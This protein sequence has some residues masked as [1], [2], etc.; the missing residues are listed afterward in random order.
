MALSLQRYTWSDFDSGVNQLLKLR[1]KKE[2]ERS[3]LLAIA[4]KNGDRLPENLMIEILSW[5]PVKN[6]LQF[7]SVC[8][9][10]R[11]VISSPQFISKHLKN[12]RKIDDNCLLAQY[13]VSHAELQLFELL[14]DEASRVLASE[15]LYSMPMYGAYICGPCDG[16][17]YLYEYD[18]S[19]R[20]LWNPA[21]NEIRNLPPL[22][23]KPDPPINTTPAKSE[24]YS[25]GVDPV[26]GDYKV[27]VIK[28]Y[29]STN[30]EDVSYPLSV[31][32]YSLRTDSWKYCGDLT[33]EYDLASNK[34]YIFVE[35]SCF[36]LGS[37]SQDGDN[38][39]EVIVSFDM[40]SDS[41][42]EISVPNYQ[43]PASKCLGIYD[44]SL[45][46]I[47]VHDDEKNL[48]LWTLSKGIW[49]KKFGIGPFP[50]VWD[51]VGHW[52]DKLILECEG[53]KLVL[54]DPKT[55]ELKD[56]AF[57]RDMSCQGVF[58]YMESLV[59]IKDK[60]KSKEDEEVEADSSQV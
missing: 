2:R 26:T 42:K 36:W 4:I 7:K 20:A 27:A 28:G 15:V 14:V 40:A 12:N 23:E 6:V 22:I 56:L 41:F 8:K 47:S 46:F 19:G 11:A 9:A 34:C 18:F 55:Q 25:F 38:S 5:L 21:I 49:T 3:A 50:D 17:Y 33:R 39:C 10:W 37:S 48:D 43:Q 58:A 16:L 30:E 44:D 51:P 31:F 57:Q 53:R 32:V 45:A 13:Y 24:V 29:W 52:K 35:G 54:C 1:S 60:N 59:S